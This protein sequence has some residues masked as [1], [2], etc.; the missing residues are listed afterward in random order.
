MSSPMFSRAEPNAADVTRALALLVGVATIGAAAAAI[1]PLAL[2]V[3]VPGVVAIATVVGARV[4]RLASELRDG[5]FER[6]L[7]ASEQSDLR[8]ERDEAVAAADEARASAELKAQFLA[9]MSH[10]IRT[11][12]NGV[13][14]MAELL[15]RTRLDADQEQMATTIQSSADALLNILND[16]LDYSKIEAGK[17]ELEA[18]DFD[19]W[20][21]IDDCAVLLHGKAADKAVELVTYVDPRIHRSHTGDQARLRQIVLNF[22]SNAVKFTLA[23]EILL[24]C[25]LLAEDDESQ[26]V[27]V[28]VR[29]SGVGI[30]RDALQRL[31]TP[32]SQADASTTRRFGGT[33]LGLSIC[34]RLTEL[35]GGR[36]YAESEEGRGSMFAL[37]LRLP[38]G[39]LS[40]SRARAFDLDLQGHAVLIAEGHATTRKLM[41]NQLT[42]TRIGID[43]AGNAITAIARLRA[44]AKSGRPF[45]MAILDMGMPGIDGLELARAI[46]DD[47]A[48]P[49]LSI[50]LASSLNERPDLLD[51]AAADVFRWLNKP[52]SGG[53][54][55]QLVHDM[56]SVCGKVAAERPTR[57]EFQETNGAVLDGVRLLVAEDNEINRRVLGGMLKKIGCSVTFA[58]DGQEALDMIQQNEFDLVLMDCQMPELNGFDA[59]QAIRALG[60]LHASV[61][62]IALTANVMPGDREACLESGMSDFLGKPVKL[63][64]LREM[65]E[66]WASARIDPAIVA[67]PELTSRADRPEQT[68]PEL[69]GAS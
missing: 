69:T 2:A 58:V 30:S 54:L 31:F 14:G 11:P 57:S 52:L 13:L 62:I 38:F 48:I 68:S 37:E 42:P 36:I 64:Q 39:D 32:F 63:D 60:G 56:A 45:T 50:A 20:Q 23:G 24:E 4:R 28:A 5:V 34:R 49:R 47:P 40:R 1:W 8:R 53:R 43:T 17:L 12:M 27:R 67:N 15:V 10:E 44:A 22:L 3:V 59:T 9:N 29:D 66:R 25:S 21:T 16:I 46:H 51:M 6:E 18:A 19:V 26:T 61:P 41:V 33:G 7:L 55:L 35:M 65:L